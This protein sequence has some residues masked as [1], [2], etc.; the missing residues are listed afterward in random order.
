MSRYQ[1]RLFKSGEDTLLIRDDGYRW[2][3]LVL[4]TP[5]VNVPTPDNPVPKGDELMDS[6]WTPLFEY[7]HCNYVGYASKIIDHL[8]ATMKTLPTIESKT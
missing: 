1:Y 2:A 5:A 3:F 4:E 6:L 7:K 8:L